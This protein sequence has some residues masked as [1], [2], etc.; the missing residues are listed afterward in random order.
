MY[1]R[2]LFPSQ[3]AAVLFDMDGTLVDSD[4]AVRRGW[5]AWA[6]EYGVDPE[7]AAAT[8]HGVPSV[9]AVQ[10]LRPD[11]SPAEAKAAG[12]RQMALQVAD[13]SDLRPIRGA[14]RLIALLEARG[15]PWA[16]VTSADRALAQARLDAVGI[17]PAV[18]VTIDDVERGKPAPESYVRAAEQLDVA[19]SRCLVVEDSEVGL[20]AGREAGAT[21]AAL[22]GQR[23]DLCIRDLE[24]LADV[25]EPPAGP[26][27]QRPR[28]LLLDVGDTLTFFDG[29]AVAALLDDATT[30]ALQLEQGALAAKRHYEARM[31]QGAS[32][33]WNSHMR[34][35]LEH[36]G[37]AS[38]VREALLPR[39]RAVHDRENLWR[40][41][42]EG[43]VAA[44][45]DLS[46][47]GMKLGVVSNSE[48]RLPQLFA[49]VGLDGLF[50]VVA[51]SAV[52][53]ASK[54]DPAIFLHALR[55]LGVTPTEALYAGDLPGVDVDG[56]RAV[57]M[58]AALVDGYGLHEG[59]SDTYRVASV[60][61]LATDLA[62]LPAW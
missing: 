40:K 53:G 18:L 57:G 19:P 7:I 2:M 55:A 45:R 13:L 5:H 3:I 16:V 56:A 6:R 42:P 23:G 59:R 10:R 39:L 22:R 24:Q 52:V 31:A 35:V 12:A 54:P 51:D 34:L 4:A 50:D 26:P 61:E 11:L 49:Q 32:H 44:L 46:R 9:D 48:G 17:E 29:A 27:R 14:H 33:D 21:L 43:L 1:L 62:R 36:A 8:A 28:A 37:V 25:W 60:M 20:A 38:A 15:I 58:H 30:S 41:V 47:L